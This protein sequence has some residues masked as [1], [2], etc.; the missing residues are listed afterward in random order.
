MGWFLDSLLAANEH[1]IDG[2][3][4][5]CG[6]IFRGNPVGPMSARWSVGISE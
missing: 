5:I 4:F 2:A 3:W 6:R 1:K